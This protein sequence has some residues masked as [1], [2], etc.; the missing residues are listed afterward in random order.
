MILSPAADVSLPLS[1]AAVARR[2]ALAV[3]QVMDTGSVG[4]MVLVGGD[5]AHAVLDAL[6]ATA[7]LIT[8]AVQEGIPCG[9][10]E[11]GSAS[12]RTVATKA[13]GFGDVS[14][15]LDTVN[16]LTTNYTALPSEAHS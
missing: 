3:R 7:L 4:S 5:G 15:L 12:G 2:L 8:G 10:I 1:G 6:G 9:Y 16:K 13:G 14:A 11:G